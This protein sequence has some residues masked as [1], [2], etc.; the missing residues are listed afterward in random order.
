MPWS[1]CDSKPIFQ[2]IVDTITVMILRGQYRAGDRLPAVR[3]FAVEA[4]VNPNTM[5]RALNIIEET[6]L[7]YTRRGDGRYVT[8]NSDKASEIREKYVKENVKVLIENLSQLGLDEKT[9]LDAVKRE[10]Y[11]ER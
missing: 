9:I 11:E 4:G 1:F 2:Q 7:I 10:L 3:D 5:Q 8:E 6:G